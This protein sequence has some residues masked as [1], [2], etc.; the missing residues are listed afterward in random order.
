MQR[1]SSS[2]WLDLILNVFLPVTLLK[3]LGT[4]APALTPLQV[5]IVALVP[6]VLMGLWSLWQERRFNAFSALG[7]L[8]V[9]LTGGFAVA[10]LG[11]PWFIVKESALPFLLG[12]GCWWT[13]LGE[14]P[15]LARILLQPGALPEERIRARLLETG[16]LTDFEGDLRRGT[17][18]FSGTF[19]FSAVLNAVV[20]WW[21][22]TPL[23]AELSEADRAQA[24]N[25]QIAQM[26]WLGF[27]VIALPSMILSVGCLFWLFRR[28]SRH[29]GW[30][31]E[32]L[33]N[34]Q[35]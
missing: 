28:L 20:A 6:P 10:G 33:L 7:V 1:S 30:P 22:F 13:S 16:K 21:V 8:N 9:G 25:D 23:A 14:K 3:K 34:G 29:T 19:F 26:T 12:V 5:L 27:V 35:G 2:V 31:L 32:E 15:F 18:Y 11:G 17:Q 24:L 4:W